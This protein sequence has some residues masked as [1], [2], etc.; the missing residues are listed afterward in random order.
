MVRLIAHLHLS[1]RS[2]GIRK[3]IPMGLLCNESNKKDT[4]FMPRGHSDP[5][6]YISVGPQGWLQQ[7][8]RVGAESGHGFW[9]FHLAFHCKIVDF[10]NPPG[11]AAPG[12]RR[13]RR[14][15]RQCYD[16]P[17]KIHRKWSK[18]LARTMAWPRLP[19][20]AHPQPRWKF[21]KWGRSSRRAR[22]FT[23]WGS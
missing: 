1:R 9:Q 3:C 17:M 23:K 2:P 13:R 19:F 12:G 11:A 16:F 7:G 18:T 8:P 22:K 15:L 6:E 5:S 14:R 21:T 4:F 20:G 10:M